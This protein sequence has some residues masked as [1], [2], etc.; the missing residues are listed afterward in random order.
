MAESVP[1]TGTPAQFLFTTAADSVL[2]TA[3]RINHDGSLIPVAGSPFLLGTPARAVTSA[4]QSLIVVGES[5]LTVLAVDKE[6]GSIQQADSVS[7][8]KAATDLSSL[9]KAE[10]QQAVM[11]RDGRFMY[12]VDAHKGELAA[13][14]I[15]AGKLVAPPES[16]PIPDGTSSIA[17]VQP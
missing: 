16:Y 10:S 8:A 9:I 13:Y 1:R 17:L 2:I 3:F 14:R 4:D 5:T 11:D 7:A 12:V 15:D 6:T